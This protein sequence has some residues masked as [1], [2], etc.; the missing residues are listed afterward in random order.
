MM[1][2]APSSDT[3]GWFARD[4]ATFAKVASIMLGEQI[5]SALPN[6]LIVAVDA[7]A[8]ADPEVGA[9]LQPMIERLRA[10][11][12]SGCEAR[13]DLTITDEGPLAQAMVIISAVPRA[14]PL[15]HGRAIRLEGNVPSAQHPPAGCRFHTRC[16]EKIGGVCEQ[17]EPPWQRASASHWIACHIPLAELSARSKEGGE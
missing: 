11:T 12:P 10:I 2:Q 7:F 14:D 1:P 8:F 6:R 13:I 9:A 5:P 4:A 17:M 16:P 3:T 15:A